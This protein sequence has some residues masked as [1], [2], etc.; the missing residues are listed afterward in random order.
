MANR[1]Y[2]TSYITSDEEGSMPVPGH[3]P[4]VGKLAEDYNRRKREE[5][6]RAKR[7]RK[8]RQTNARAIRQWRNRKEPSG[9]GERLV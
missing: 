4:T 9:S 3:G 7:R 5:R 8:R 2:L 6:Q 1:R